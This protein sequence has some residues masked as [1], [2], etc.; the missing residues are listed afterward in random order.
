MS[1][2]RFRRRFPAVFLVLAF[3]GFAIAATA[4][5]WLIGNYCSAEDLNDDSGSDTAAYRLAH[6]VSAVRAA[7]PSMRAAFDDDQDEEPEDWWVGFWCD[8]TI[9]DYAIALFAFVLGLSSIAL[10]LQ[11]ARA[12]RRTAEHAEELRDAV[13]AL[14]K[15]AQTRAGTPTAT[16]TAEG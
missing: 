14:N 1:K 13:A 16:D 8:I 12:A 6:H 3:L 5:A 4:P 9:A 7:P 10:W 15:A 11:T 2:G